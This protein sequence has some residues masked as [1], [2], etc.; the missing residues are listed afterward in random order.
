MKL[1][2][3]FKNRQSSNST[4]LKGIKKAAP[5]NAAFLIDHISIVIV[6]STN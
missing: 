3:K 4:T 1:Q 5:F 6:L 2:T